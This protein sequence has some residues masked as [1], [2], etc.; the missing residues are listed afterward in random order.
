MEESFKKNEF[1]YVTTVIYVN[2]EMDRGYVNEIMNYIDQYL[3]M[4]MMLFPNLVI[5]KP[6]KVFPN[7]TINFF[8]IK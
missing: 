1:K 3:V 5:L 2:I 4:M 6:K 8:I 7:K